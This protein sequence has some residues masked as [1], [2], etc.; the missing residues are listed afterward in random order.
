MPV[1]RREGRQGWSRDNGTSPH[2]LAKARRFEPAVLTNSEE[3][4]TSQQVTRTDRRTVDEADFA[5]AVAF[6]GAASALP[7]YNE[8]GPGHQGIAA[9]PL[10]A[11]HQCQ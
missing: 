6:L 2:K 1:K 3:V 5:C 9:I 8:T 11:V 7:F 10:D 4:C